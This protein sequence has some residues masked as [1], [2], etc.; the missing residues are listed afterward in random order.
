MNKYLITIVLVFSFSA[1]SSQEI[2]TGLPENQLIKQAWQEKNKAGLELSRSSVLHKWIPVQLPFF[3]DFRDYL[4]YPDT[5]F[6]LNDEAWVNQD[7][8]KRAANLGAATM[9]A[10]DARG[11]IYSNAS[12]FPFLADRLTSR[13]IRLDSVFSPV[14]AAISPA[15]SVYLSFFYQP[16]GRGDEPEENDSLVL[17]FGRYGQ[18][19]A[20]SYIDSISIP[21]SAYIGP[22][23]TIFPGDTL[24]S[25]CDTE[26]GMAVFDTLYH[27]DTV[28]LPCDSVYFPSINWETIWSVP[29]MPLDTFLARNGV[30][31]KQVMI[32]ITDTAYL[33]PDFFFRFYNLASLSTIPSW[34]S[35]CDQWNIDYVY[36][37]L[38]RSAADTIYRDIGFVERSPSMLRN[39]ELMPYD[40]YVNN[41]T[42]ALK[43]TFKLY[44]SNLD[45]NTFNTLYKYRLSDEGSFERTYDGGSCNLLPFSQEQYQSCEICPQHACPPWKFLFPLDATAETARFK[46]EHILLGDFTSADTISDTMTYFQ[47]FRNFYAYDDGTP[48]AG[49]GL[50]PA[51]AMLAYKFELNRP[52]TLRA[53]QMFFNKV[54]NEANDMY[55]D[56]AVWQDNNGI[57]GEMIYIQENEKPRF[58]SGIYEYQTYKLDSALP[59]FNVF[60][61]GWI[62]SEGKNLNVGYDKY[63]NAREHTFYNVIGNWQQSLGEGALMIRP[64]LGEEIVSDLNEMPANQA[65]L[66]IYPNPVSGYEVFIDIPGKTESRVNAELRIYNMFGQLVYNEAYRKKINI[67]PLGKGMYLVRLYDKKS[68]KV[69]TG[70][71]IKSN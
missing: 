13:P 47:E 22:N 15:D 69:F 57:P 24:F 42:N 37:N 48:E 64:L 62:Q 14:P 51:G 2:I 36:L 68:G 18:D 26:W 33:K 27:F 11:R 8:P 4:G 52:D 12:I 40:Q 70:K 31:F 49:Y 38:G 60:Y 63:N 53:I 66:R 71:L 58:G 6:W 45:D 46:I 67:G 10:I 56:L 50:E 20:F 54:A 61:M 59:V 1:L 35:N 44:I 34:K 28:M 39:Y 3:D 29:G 25:P 43:D 19:S 23:D 17:Q 32:P 41:P 65:S 16:Q 7:F 9:D 55:F 21:V 5:A 30:H